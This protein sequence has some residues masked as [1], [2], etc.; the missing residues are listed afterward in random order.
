MA[1]TW[2]KAASSGALGHN[3]SLPNGGTTTTDLNDGSASTRV[4]TSS[5]AFPEHQAAGFIF[6]DELT[7]LNEIYASVKCWQSSGEGTGAWGIGYSVSASPSSW[8]SLSSGALGIDVAADYDDSGAIIQNL[9]AN[10]NGVSVRALRV[11]VT[12]ADA[13]EGGVAVAEFTAQRAGT[14][15]CSLPAIPAPVN[16]P[17]VCEGAKLTFTWGPSVG[18][19]GYDVSVDGGNAIDVG[20]V[21]TYVIDP[22]TIGQTYEIRVRAYNLNCGQ[23]AWSNPV[24]A[25]ACIACGMDDIVENATA[26]HFEARIYDEDGKRVF[27]NPDSVSALSW[28]YT[29]AGGMDEAS[30]TFMKGFQPSAE[31]GG[32]TLKVYRVDESIPRWIGTIQQPEMSLDIREEHRLVAYGR[33][34]SMNRV[35]AN[36]VYQYPGGTDLA[37]FVARALDNYEKR[38]GRTYPRDIQNSGIQLERLEATGVPM[39]EA[40]DAIVNNSAGQIVWGWEVN[41]SDGSE[42]FFLRPRSQT[43]A[44]QYWVGKNIKLL[45]WPKEYQGIV[46]AVLLRGG[47]AKFPQLFTNPGFEFPTNPTDSSG[48]L[49]LKGGFE[50]SGG[51]TYINGASRKQQTGGGQ[52]ATAHTGSYYLELDHND[53]EAYQDVDV[54]DGVAYRL[55]LFNRR[56]KGSYANTGQVIIEGRSSPGGTVVSTQ[57]VGLAP[58][59][60][61]WSGGQGT[62]QASG[63]GVM[64]PVLFDDPSIVSARIRIKATNGNTT[65]GLLIDD[66]TFAAVGAVGQHGWTTHVQVPGNSDNR[67]IY[68]DW[69][70]ESAAW[71]GLYGVRISVIADTSHRCYIN[72][73][74]TDNPRAGG[75][76]PRVTPEMTVHHA[77]RVRMAPG[78][79]NSDTGLARL[80]LREYKQDGGQTQ[81]TAGSSITIPNDGTWV[82]LQQEITMDGETVIVLPQLAFEKDGVYDVDGASLRDAA[83]DAPGATTYDF[84]SGETF[85]RYV[86]AEEV[87]DPGSPAAESVNQSW[88]RQEIPLANPDIIVWNSAAEGIL[89]AYFDRNAVPYYRPALTVTHDPDNAPN[90]CSGRRLRVSGLDEELIDP[91]HP[92]KTRYTYG[93]SRLSILVELTRERPTLAKY[94]RQKNKSAAGGGSVSTNLGFLSNNQGNGDPG[95]GSPV[96]LTL[97]NDA[98]T[99]ANGDGVVV[100]L[101]FNGSLTV[102]A[103]ANGD[104]TSTGSIGL[105]PT[106]EALEVISSAVGL[107]EQTSADVFTIRSIGVGAGSSIPDRDAADTR[108]VRSVGLSVPS[109]LLAVTNTPVTSVGTIAVS[110]ATQAARTALLGPASG[111]DAPPT[112]RLIKANDLDSLA[113][114]VLFGRYSGTAGAGQE[115]T[116]GAG[117]SLDSGTGVLSNSVSALSDGDKGD[118]TVSSSGSVWTIDT[119]AVTDAKLRQSAGLSVIGRSANTTG[120]IADITAG[121]DGYVLRRSGTALGFGQVATAGIADDAVT[122]AKIQNVTDNRVLGRAA[123]SSG[124]VQE[125][126]VSSPLTIGAGSLGFDGTAALDNVARVTVRKNS[127]ANVGSRRRLNLTEGANITLTVT[128]DG[129]GEEI[130]VTIASS[131]TETYTGTVTS[132]A[133]TAPSEIS[134]GG[135]PVTSSG[136][137]A[138][139]WAN[140]TQN[141]VFASPNGSTGTP[142]FRALVAADIPALSYVTSVG[143]SA[144]GIFSV[145]GSPVTS[146]G[147]IALSL[148]TQSANR[149]WAGP[150]SGADAAPTFRALVSD[151]IPSLAI[152]KITSA[153]ASVL[154][155]RYAGTSGA[156]QEITIGSGLSLNSGTGVLSSSLVGLSDGDKGDITV[157]S[158]G[159]VWTI[160]N[161]AVTYAKIQNVSATDRLLGR[162]TTGAGDIEELAVTGGLEFTGS[163]GIQRSALTGDV[164]AS[165]GSGS[166]T[167]AANAVTDAKLRQSAGL[168]VVG[169]SANT[170]GNVADITA[171]TDGHVL[172]LSGTSI[173]FGT[174]ATAGIADDAV[175]FAK[176]QNITDNRLLGRSAGTDGDMQHIT[177][178]SPLT[179][180]SGVLDFDETVALG[181]V[182]RT[183]VRKNTGADVGSRRRLNFIEG[184]NITLTI[185]DDGAG[186]EVDITIAAAGATVPGSDKQI[187]YNASGVLGAESGFEYDYSTNQATIPGLTVTEDLL[188]SGDISPTQLTADQDNY[189]PTGLSTATVLR[190]TSDGTRVITGIAGGADGRMLILL[191]VGNN[192][193]RLA[194]EAAASTAANRFALA[195]ARPIYAGTGAVLWYDSTSSRW[196]CLDQNTTGVTDGDKGDITVS[197]SGATWTIDNNAVSLGKI[198]QITTDRLLGR[199]TAG[200]GDV[201]QL[202]VGGGIEFTGSGGIQ[203]SALTGDVT[204]SAGSNATTIAN[205]AVT[206]AKVQNITDN[207]VLGRAAGST[208]DTQ[209]LTVSSPLTIGS[210]AL[211]FDQSVALGNVARTTVRK[212]TGGAD[213][214]SRRR[215]NFVEGSN[216]TLTIADDSVNEEIDI[217]IAS[218]SLADG[219]KGDVTVSGSGATWTID[220]NAVTFAKMQQ[221]TTDRLL[222]RDTALTGNVE[223]LTVGGGLEFTGAGGIQRSALTGDVAASAGSNTTTIA[224]NAVSNAK[225][226]QSAGLSV[227][228]RSANTTG[229]VA[230][231]TAASDGQALRRSG[232]T[233]GFGAIDLSNSSAVTVPGS[234]SQILYRWS[235]AVA[236]SSNLT[237]DPTGPSL[238]LLGDLRV[239]RLIKAYGT[240]TPTQITADQNNYAPTSGDTSTFWR[241]S[242]DAARNIT[243][244]SAGTL[245][246]GRLLLLYNVGSFAITLKDASTSSTAANRFELNGDFVLGAG[247]ATL[248]Y[249]DATATRWIM[250]Q[251]NALVLD[252]DK[253]DITVSSSGATWTIDN[254]VVSDAKLRQGAGLSVIGVTGNAT[255]NVADIAAGSDGHVLRRSGT[256]LAFGTIA[257]AGIADDAVTFAK[258]QNI[259]D[260][261]LIGRSAGSSG[262]AQEITVSSPITLSSGVVDFDETVA[263]GN[264]ARTTVRKNAGADV[265]SRR[266][267]NFT[268]GSNIT[269]TIADDS[270]NEEIDITIAASG[271]GGT[272]AGSTNYIQYNNAGAFGAEAGFEYDP[273]TN[274]ATIP[275]LTLTEDFALS[276]DITPSQIT[277]NQNDYAPTG[278]AT[279]SVWRLSSDAARDVTGFSGGADGRFLIVLNVGSYTIT[280]KNASTSSTAANRFSMASDLALE[281]GAG[282]IFV[283]D[284]TQSRWTLA[285]PRLSTTAP[286]VFDFI[287]TTGDGSYNYCRIYVITDATTT[288]SLGADF[289]AQG[290]GVA[291]VRNKKTSGSLT[292]N[293][294]AGWTM[295]DGDTTLAVGEGAI[296]LVAQPGGAGS[297]QI[298]TL[299]K[300]T[301]GSGS[302]AGSTNY[303]Q[304][305][306]SGSFGAEA[307]FEYDATN[308]QA[309]IPGLTVTEDFALSGDVS[310]SQITADQ[311]DYAPTGHATATVMRLTSDARRV[312]TG[313]SGGADGRVLRIM[314]VGSYPIVLADA[315]TASTAANR[316]DLSFGDCLIPPK[317]SA[318]LFYDATLSRWVHFGSAMSV[319]MN[320]A[321]NAGRVAY[322]REDFLNGTTTMGWGLSSSTSGTGASNSSVASGQ[323]ER[324]VISSGTG[325]TT[326]GRAGVIT[327]T[328]CFRFGGGT[329]YF[330]ARCRFANGVPD[331][332]ESYTARIG[333]IDSASAESTNGV[334]FRVANGVNS[335]NWQ[336]V[337]RDNSTESVTNSSV[338]QVTSGGQV[339]EFLINAA[340][341]SI[342][343]FIDG[344]SVGSAITTNIPTASGRETGCGF[345]ILKSAGTTSRTIQVDYIEWWTEFTT[346]R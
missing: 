228:G 294:S 221:V 9:S 238:S 69:A 213:V 184:T 326:T 232:T 293:A 182:A 329:T 256:T 217:T 76:Y 45:H 252:G 3:G 267:L 64:I 110:L 170:T 62:T 220:N 22:A 240:I 327:G 132:V 8:T 94:L 292:V 255:A 282:C 28:S 230:D 301:T 259:T 48:N 59:S 99:V 93:N 288:Q 177:V 53:E 31:L 12:L 63:D 151:D 204:A 101:S 205:D 225:F 186:E 336:L 305:N 55:L 15:G 60:T 98:V 67:I 90:P 248:L 163:G 100:T 192:E 320:L 138:L 102:S 11:V 274:Q 4:E 195:Q 324:G 246:D 242:S 200:T 14:V 190:L 330:R 211:G 111:P 331:G 38:K 74:P 149:V 5:A 66:V 315:S 52:A 144:P 180:S 243:G 316:F 338:A 319:R 169:R 91:L 158:T 79:L 159:A 137:L 214:G 312:I 32:K 236:S 114:G 317:L 270:V 199:D 47:R 70:N 291:I 171:V 121:S 120:N 167:I 156:G 153:A 147:T 193:I 287:G 95:V 107:V 197:S 289:A 142:G 82:E 123:G 78:G 13:A 140:Q 20:N 298:Y 30:I 73:Y 143:L 141:K 154:F 258:I 7:P 109:A 302:P 112:F 119:N 262:D 272:P 249:Y 160:D 245:P 281:A 39:R 198:Q 179:L 201:E 1:T 286:F 283:Y 108:Y 247:A 333:F 346:P 136:T 251:Q 83:A 345:F 43:V 269:L 135:S 322:G 165:A 27:L 203:R 128:D 37:F 284:S 257:T 318:L 88:G 343:G 113:G 92:A 34:E 208:G 122:Y 207:R 279:A 340:G 115:I 341:T 224:A 145:G 42:Q 24:E 223:E 325:T 146:S 6:F 68:A 210:G 299:L 303:I 234:D 314:N 49:L 216:V 306:A 206:F 40:I 176:I 337:S 194:S 183:T 116:I 36:F 339:L 75:F 57:T 278:H 89:K 191:N 161:D 233:I 2:K 129:V 196:R 244:I 87:A 188:F 21:L 86:T 17:E 300:T 125:L 148:A 215:L 285:T 61:V 150:S 231:I 130:D 229:D 264:V 222:G 46:N 297:N 266:R 168:S 139:S 50:E 126:T 304:Y 81:F 127:G 41:P 181:N 296:Y 157:S 97:Q 280:L 261:R 173:G 276:G 106:L 268:E 16:A 133:L 189:N 23:S 263:L 18:A 260:A 71:E 131:F 166:T 235:S 265:G 328:N 72:P 155:G 307:G 310:P 290:G 124:D 202:T 250:V 19:D 85:E 10:A 162:D 227:V 344:V 117:L 209:E 335:V 29:E 309:T 84:L 105:G 239:S 218:A 212:N 25:T 56:E 241:I 185:A 172:R 77:W 134:V 33:M 273:S 313:I 253:G 80:E 323:G 187:V 237:F 164:T 321:M 152:S 275:G 54:S 58:D 178:S 342:E 51:W 295:V 334:F 103:A 226:R 308:N 254:N 219:D 44:W 65:E 35:L 104:G 96:G 332:T 277:A 271:G 174:V 175:T 118:I 26:Y 311:N